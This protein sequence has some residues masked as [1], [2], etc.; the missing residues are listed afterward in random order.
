MHVVF[1]RLTQATIY[2]S[3]QIN[4]GK[5]CALIFMLF[6]IFKTLI[7]SQSLY[8]TNTTPRP[9]YDSLPPAV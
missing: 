5:S 3:L 8:F 4:S 2:N 6:M 9:V 1:L 7:Y